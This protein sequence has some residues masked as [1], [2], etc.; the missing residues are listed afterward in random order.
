MTSFLGP[1]TIIFPAAI[2][3]A[4]VAR[5]ADLAAR[6]TAARDGIAHEEEEAA[7][8]VEEE[9]AGAA[10]V[11][12]AAGPLPLSSGPEESGRQEER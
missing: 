9:E 1:S 8:A 10:V 7:A 5:P 12:A 6:P 11:V 4:P 2:P 3:A